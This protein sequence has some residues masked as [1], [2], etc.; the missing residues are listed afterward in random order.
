MPKIP[1]G[2]FV[3]VACF[4]QDVIED[5]AGT[6]T[7]VKIIDTLTHTESGPNPPMDLTP[8]VFN[9]K[10]V[11]MLKSGA[12]KGRHE[13]RIVPELPNGSTTPA[14]TVTAHFEG[15]HK[16]QNVI[17]DMTYQFTMEGLYWFNAFLGETLLTSMPIYVKYNRVIVNSTAQPGR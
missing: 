1:E 3:Q 2:P 15:E 13:I 7:L 11:L 6:Y 4:C 16:G 9:L 8:F 14:L 17:A 10:L 12:A 5:K